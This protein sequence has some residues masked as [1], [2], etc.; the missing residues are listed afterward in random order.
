MLSC[1]IQN[2]KTKK[3]NYKI[4]TLWKPIYHKIYRSTCEWGQVIGRG[5]ECVYDTFCPW[6]KKLAV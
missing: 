1:E 3:I 5:K 4:K 6:E 2:N